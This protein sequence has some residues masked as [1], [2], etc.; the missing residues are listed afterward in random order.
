MA[1]ARRLALL[2]MALKLPHAHP[3]PTSNN[4]HGL[5]RQFRMVDEASDKVGLVLPAGATPQGLSD[6]PRREITNLDAGNP[7]ARLVAD[8]HIL[9]LALPIMMTRGSCLVRTTIIA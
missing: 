5:A 2:A 9:C 6:L 4:D 1:F 3:Q 7:I 8:I